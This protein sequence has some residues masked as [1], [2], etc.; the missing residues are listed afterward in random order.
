MLY[1]PI[2]FFIIINAHYPAVV[3]QSYRKTSFFTHWVKRRY[4]G[5]INDLLKKNQTWLHLFS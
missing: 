5:T 4:L 1:Q 2:L 3:A